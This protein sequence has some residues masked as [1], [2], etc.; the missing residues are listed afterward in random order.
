MTNL[1]F[2][3]FTPVIDS[4]PRGSLVMTMDGGRDCT[5][6]LTVIQSYQGDR[7]LIMEGYVQ[8]NPVCD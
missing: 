5:S 1:T 2:G 7:S 4:G 3:L 6:F 8:W